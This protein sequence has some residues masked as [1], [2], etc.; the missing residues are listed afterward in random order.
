[1]VAHP[2]TVQPGATCCMFRECT[3]QISRAHLMLTC[4]HSAGSTHHEQLVLLGAAHKHTQ[5]GKEGHNVLVQLQEE[6]ER[7]SATTE[8]LQLAMD[9]PVCHTQVACTGTHNPSFRVVGFL[10]SARS[11]FPCI[12]IHR[13]RRRR[14]SPVLALR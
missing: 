2:P 9:R 1:M 4:W 8:E 10:G 12:G 13:G 11:F 7:S 3:L 14:W 6:R 5:G